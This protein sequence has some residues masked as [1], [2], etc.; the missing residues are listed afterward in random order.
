MCIAQFVRR[1]A[2]LV[3]AISAS[4]LAQV[5]YQHPTT[6]PEP[7]RMNYV[8]RVIPRKSTQRPAVVAKKH[9]G[10]HRAGKK[11]NGSK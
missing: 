4:A 9:V 11:K 1:A 7:R 10:K 5:P 2:I 3:L 6:P 8:P